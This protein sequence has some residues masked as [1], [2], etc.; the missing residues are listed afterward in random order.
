MSAGRTP[1]A[2]GGSISGRAGAGGSRAARRCASAQ[3]PALARRRVVFGLA[4]PGPALLAAMRLLVDGRPG[5]PRGL[6]CR[7]STLLVAFLDVLG[8]AFLLVGVARFVAARHG[9]LLMRFEFKTWNASKRTGFR[10]GEACW[11]APAQAEV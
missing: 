1:L 6:P 11:F 5:A 9:S 8:L 7:D 2:G 10:A 3:L 4:A